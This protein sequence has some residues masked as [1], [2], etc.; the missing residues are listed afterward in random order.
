MVQITYKKLT[1]SIGSLNIKIIIKAC[2]H[3][4]E[5]FCGYLNCNLFIKWFS[6]VYDIINVV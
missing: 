6:G 1:S 2:V 3:L 5:Q 4:L